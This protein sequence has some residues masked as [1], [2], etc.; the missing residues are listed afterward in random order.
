MVSK[1]NA[2][3]SQAPSGSALPKPFLQQGPCTS[4]CL[5]YDAFQIVNLRDML[6]KWSRQEA[7]RRTTKT[8]PLSV[9]RLL[10]GFNIDGQLRFGLLACGSLQ[11][12]R[13]KARQN[14]I[15]HEASLGLDDSSEQWSTGVGIRLRLPTSACEQSLHPLAQQSPFSPVECGEIRALAEQDF[16]DE[17]VWYGSH[18][19]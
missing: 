14:W 2:L 9:Q 3:V 1:F 17:L 18:C 5:H 16:A 19:H 7:A 6:V 15:V 10:Y 4:V 11:A 12:G 13:F 8:C